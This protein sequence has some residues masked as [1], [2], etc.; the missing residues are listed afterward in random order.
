MSTI[1][2]LIYGPP[3]EGENKTLAD[4]T[5][6]NKL[7]KNDSDFEA[8]AEWKLGLASKRKAE[9]MEKKMKDGPEIIGTLPTDA[10]ILIICLLVRYFFDSV[11]VTSPAQ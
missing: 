5:N 11:Y 4:A 9:D 8:W 6:P 10:D 2:K 1:E 3:L 7:N